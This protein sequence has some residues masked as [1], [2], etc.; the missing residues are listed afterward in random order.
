VTARGYI[1]ILL[2]R[3]RTCR[4]KIPDGMVLYGIIVDTNRQHT[5][6]TYCFHP[7]RLL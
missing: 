4:W 3:S 7:K 6:S 2:W 5:A 1:M